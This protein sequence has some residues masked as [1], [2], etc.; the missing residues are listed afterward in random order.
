MTICRSIGLTL[1]HG[2]KYFRPFICRHLLYDIIASTINVRVTVSVYVDY[3]FKVACFQCLFCF[4]LCVNFG[5]F[6]AHCVFFLIIILEG[7]S[8][9]NAI[10]CKLSTSHTSPL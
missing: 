4:C 5:F 8:D 10:D 7:P 1:D 2:F 9:G 3:N 6:F